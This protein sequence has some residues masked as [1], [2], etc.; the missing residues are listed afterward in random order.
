MTAHPTTPPQPVI[1]TSDQTTNHFQQFLRTLLLVRG[2]IILRSPFPPFPAN[3][4][5][6]QAHIPQ[7]PHSVF[8]SHLFAHHIFDDSGQQINLGALLQGPQKDTR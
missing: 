7:H 4:S 5:T 2:T 3:S 8:A 1:P 6:Q